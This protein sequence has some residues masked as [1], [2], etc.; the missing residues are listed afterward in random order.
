MD[1]GDFV[2]FTMAFFAALAGLIWLLTYLE[3]TL[4]SGPQNRNGAV[5]GAALGRPEADVAPV[6]EIREQVAVHRGAFPTRRR[7][8]AARSE[9]ASRHCNYVSIDR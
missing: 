7:F 5:N 6:Q 3:Q 1:F 4:K 9:A 8:D 2:V